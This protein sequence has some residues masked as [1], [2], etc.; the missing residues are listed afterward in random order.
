MLII[1]NIA[2]IS[3]QTILRNCIEPPTAETNCKPNENELQLALLMPHGQG[4]GTV[5]HRHWPFGRNA[6]R[7]T[8]C[9]ILFWR[10]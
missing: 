5:C 3:L 7:K 10:I 4:R 8:V 2:M 1:I 6:G 9:K